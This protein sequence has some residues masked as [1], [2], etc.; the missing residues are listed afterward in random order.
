MTDRNSVLTRGWS[1]EAKLAHYSIPE[2]NSGCL[3]W[4]GT[5]YP[6]GHA[7]L[8]WDGRLQRAHRLAWEAVNGPIPPG[9]S[10]CHHCDVR[11]CI[12]V[13]HLFLGA[14]DDNMA[15]M[16]RKG[17][18]ARQRG[19]SNGAARLTDSQAREIRDAVGSYRKLGARFGVS[20]NQIYMI[21]HGKTWGHV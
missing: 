2:P 14:H 13:D 12:N 7:C 15:D 1:L 19:E 18:A 4:L 20:H 5:V 3:L 10:A 11:P 16:A 8:F 9:L 6:S 21:K 17:R